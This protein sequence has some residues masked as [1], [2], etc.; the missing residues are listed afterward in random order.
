MVADKDQV[1][2]PLA[3]VSR[4]DSHLHCIHEAWIPVLTDYIIKYEAGAPILL[5]RPIGQHSHHC[6]AKAGEILVCITE[7]KQHLACDVIW[8][9][10]HDPMVAD[11]G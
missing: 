1:V 3:W 9:V 10:Q 8:G 7:K 2:F 11:T 4:I 6:A 5:H